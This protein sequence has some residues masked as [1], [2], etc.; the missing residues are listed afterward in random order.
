MKKKYAKEE[1]KEE[2]NENKK[3]EKKRLNL[4]KSKMYLQK[5]LIHLKIKAQ[6]NG[7]IYK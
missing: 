6:V 3:E 1:E 4:K 5:V 2:E 7:K